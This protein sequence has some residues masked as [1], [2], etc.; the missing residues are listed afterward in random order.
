[1]AGINLLVTKD[2]FICS[3]CLENLRDP[4]S[5]PC[6]HNFC[7]KCITECWDQMG[8]C[9]CPQCRETYAPRLVLCRNTLLAEVVERLA[10]SDVDLDVSQNVAGPDDVECDVCSEK[11]CTAVKSCLTC[12]ASYCESHIQP[13]YMNAAWKNHRLLNPTANLPQKICTKHHK[14]LKFFCESDETCIC[15]MCVVTGHKWHAMA[16]LETVRQ[17]KQAILKETVS[18]IQKRLDKKMKKLDEA[19]KSV[20]RIKISADQE[21]QKTKKCFSDLIHYIEKT[22]QKVVDHIGEQEKMETEKAKQL[23]KLLEKEVKELEKRKGELTEFSET[24]DNIHFLQNFPSQCVPLGEEDSLNI[25]MTKDFSFENMRKKLY[26]LKG[27]LDKVSQWGVEQITPTVGE[28]LACTIQSSGPETREEFLQYACQFTLDLDTAHP[29]ICLSDGNRKMTLM[30]DP[31]SYPDHPS[32]F[33]CYQQVLCKESL[34]GP[35]CYYEV[36]WKGSAVLGVTKERISRKGWGADCRLGGNN[37]SW[38]LCCSASGFYARY[39]NM[40]T[41]VSAPCD[42]RIGVFLDRTSSSLSFY[43]IRDKM[44]LL[45]KFQASFDE[46]LYMGF[47]LFHSPGFSVTICNLSPSA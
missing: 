34:R 28:A 29:K 1:M 5:I 22:Q 25:T 15:T 30:K 43:S 6:G 9:R 17:R 33:N 16:E 12:L 19:K 27:Y 10:H 42:S 41:L 26:N 35:R 44:T 23:I 47:G 46:P 32:R 36:E 4:V 18:T 38:S 31:L 40:E 39:N 37:M 24:E 20:D 3:I 11:K 2:E 13:H 21:V 14:G 45:Y 8:V 7:M